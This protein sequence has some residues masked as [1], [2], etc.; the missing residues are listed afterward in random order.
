MAQSLASGLATSQG[1]SANVL[2]DLHSELEVQQRA[3]LARTTSDCESHQVQSSTAVSLCRH[4]LSVCLSVSQSVPVA[5]CLS[6]CMC[7]CMSDY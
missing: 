4:A 6:I 2:L 3:S 7:V 5:T 1:A